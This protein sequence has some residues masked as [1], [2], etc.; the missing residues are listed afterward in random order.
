MLS[1]SKSST[2]EELIPARMV[3]PGNYLTI[4]NERGDSELSEVIDVSVADPSQ[5]G[6]ANVITECPNET[7][8][9]N[10]IVGSYVVERNLKGTQ[11]VIR[12]TLKT[13]YPIFGMKA[14]TSTFKALY[15][16]HKQVHE[17]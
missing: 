7:I 12:Q 6:L 3:K 9:V 11:G 13:I 10:G 5:I 1:V 15:W 8:V 16:F 4:V 2:A 14:T 17:F